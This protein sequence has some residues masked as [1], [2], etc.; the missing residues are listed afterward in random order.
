MIAHRITDQDR[1]KRNYIELQSLKKTSIGYLP[2]I[3]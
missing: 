1:A 3:R 2:T